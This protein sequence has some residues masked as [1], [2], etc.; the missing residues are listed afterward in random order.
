[1]HKFM[2][3]AF[4]KCY[5]CQKIKH[6]QHRLY[7]LIKSSKMPINAW[8]SIVLDFIIKL[9]KSKKSITKIIY[10]SKLVIIN[11]LTKYKYFILY[12]K[13][14]LAENLAY[15]FYKYVIANHKMPEKI[16]FNHDKLFIFKF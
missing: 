12:K 10:D 1:M 7:R 5:V 2:E 6:E 14:S 13:T 4:Q 15:I 11:R 8:K 3:N 16:I 9:P